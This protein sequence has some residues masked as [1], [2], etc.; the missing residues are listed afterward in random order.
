MIVNVL[1]ICYDYPC[2]ISSLFPLGEKSLPFPKRGF[3]IGDSIL[4]TILKVLFF[5]AYDILWSDLLAVVS[6][7]AWFIF[8]VVNA[9]QDRNRG[10][11]FIQRGIENGGQGG[12][13][14]NDWGFGQ[15]VPMFLFLI[16]VWVAIEAT[17]GTSYPNQRV[18]LTQKNDT[19][20]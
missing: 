3:E 16:T 2:A 17:L 13:N 10:H 14:E 7:L 5:I 4:R 6:L 11:R 9:V 15:F 19:R 20:S 12:Q 18:D 8:G 1:F